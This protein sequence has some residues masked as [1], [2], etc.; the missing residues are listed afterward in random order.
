MLTLVKYDSIIAWSLQARLGKPKPANKVEQS[1]YVQE[2]NMKENCD[3]A[4]K[5][6]AQKLCKLNLPSGA[7]KQR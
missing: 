7:Y 4:E 5:L 1:F 6:L 3:G 2:L